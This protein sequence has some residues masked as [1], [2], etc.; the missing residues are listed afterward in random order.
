MGLAQPAVEFSGVPRNRN[1]LGLNLLPGVRVSAAITA[2]P[3]VIYRALKG[4][5]SPG[6]RIH[7]MLKRAIPPSM[8]RR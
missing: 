6:T 5:L 3:S 1:G 7:A 2:S 8:L 4:C